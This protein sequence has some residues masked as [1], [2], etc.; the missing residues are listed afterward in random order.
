VFKRWKPQA[1]LHFAAYAYVG[2]SNIDPLK[3]YDN[4][5]GGTA[6]LL[7]A[8][9]AL[10]CRNVIFSSSWSTFGVPSQLPLTEGAA[11]TQ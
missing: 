3:Y 4:N 9:A 8:C 7:N 11:Q 10:E 5:I 2:E 6:K 1:V